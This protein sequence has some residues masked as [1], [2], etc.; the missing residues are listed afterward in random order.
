VDT[1]AGLD[2]VA[3]RKILSPR[4]ELNRSRPARS[5]VAVLTATPAP[6]VRR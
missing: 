1:R 2:A 5:L 4:R 3:K 6:V